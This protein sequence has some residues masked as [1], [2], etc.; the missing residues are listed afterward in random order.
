MMSASFNP[1]HKWLA[2]PP[3]DQPANHYRLLAIELWEDDAEV[4]ANAAEQRISHLRILEMGENTQR[5]NLM[6]DAII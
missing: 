1:Y 2:I 3:E 4:I 5:R 6:V